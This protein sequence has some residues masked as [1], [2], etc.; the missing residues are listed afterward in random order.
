MYDRLPFPHITATK[1]EEQ[2]AQMKD[3]LLQFKEE[4]EFILMNLS[5]DNLS[6]DLVDKLH[7]LG[8]DIK[9]TSEENES[10]FQQMSN[11]SLSVSDVINSPAFGLAVEGKIPTFSVNYETG[12]LEYQK[13]E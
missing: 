10:K 5:V 4:L 8:A 12:N 13:G 2:L 9:K 1:P 3:Y 6:Q 7:S 11:K